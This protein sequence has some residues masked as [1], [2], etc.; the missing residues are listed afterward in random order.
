MICPDYPISSIHADTLNRGEFAKNLANILLQRSFASSFTIGMYGEWGSGKTSLINMVLD[1]AEKSTNKPII[2]KFNPWLCTD[3]HQIVTQFFKQLASAIKLQVQTNNVWKTI[4]K[5]ADLFDAA[6]EISVL[7]PIIKQVGKVLRFVARGHVDDD[8]RDLQATKDEITKKLLEIDSRIIVAI[9]DIDRLS[10]KEIVAVFQLVKAIADFPNTVYLLAFDYNVVVNALSTVQ[11]G[12]GREYLE[13]IIQVPFE[14]PAPSIQSIH[15]TFFTRMNEVLSGIPETKWDG[16]EW[17]ELFEYGFKLYLLSIRDVIRFSN[18]FILKYDSMLQE[19]DAVDLLGLTCLQVFE[20]VL[21]SLIPSYKSM[22]CGDFFHSWPYSEYHN[23]PQDQTKEAV[24]CLLNK[25]TVVNERAARNILCLLFPKIRDVVE[26]PSVIGESYNR[27][28]FIVRGKIAAPECFDRF[29]TLTLERESIPV[30]LINYIL[31]E[32]N[33]PDIMQEVQCLYRDSEDKVIRLIEEMCAFYDKERH[34]IF[35]SSSRSVL[36]IKC[37]CMLLSTLSFNEKNELLYS[38]TSIFLYCIDSALQSMEVAQR[39]DCISSVFFDDVFSVNCLALLLR[40]FGYQHGLY[41]DAGAKSI[42]KTLTI[43]DVRNLERAFYS[44]ATNAVIK[45]TF[46]KTDNGLNFFWMLEKINPEFTSAYKQRLVKSGISL[47]RVITLCSSEG[48]AGTGRS[49]WYTWKIYKDKL[50]EFIDCND[51]YSRIII[52]S[53][54]LQFSLLSHKT[55]MA[56]CAFML[57]MEEKVD[58]MWDSVPESKVIERL[59]A[60]TH[61]KESV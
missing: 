1:Y 38:T 46:I 9:D 37:L 29:F 3:E 49:V 5:Y 25:N 14:I 15:N 30:T 8:F 6:E 32:A 24:S 11:S 53:K 28:S 51:A 31:F 2:L 19:T 20:P 44:R 26:K 22:L 55:H 59:N 60:L 21:Y 7:P 18:V 40:H 42:C 33:E 12:D 35:P 27:G 54:T 23:K 61:K 36:I 56:V 50:D 43:G 41:H 10:E 58:N 47:A 57:Y 17:R 39:Y 34:A 13:K 16:D 4:N 48:S 52:Y 45:R